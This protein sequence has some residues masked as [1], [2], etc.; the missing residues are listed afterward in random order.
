M[1]WM[2]IIVL[3]CLVGVVGDAGADDGFSSGCWSPEKSVQFWKEIDRRRRSSESVYKV[4]FCARGGSTVGHAFVAW[5][6]YDGKTRQCRIPVGYGFYPREGV[7][8]VSSVFG[9]VPGA[10]LDEAKNPNTRLLTHCLI[11]NVDEEVYKGSQRVIQKWK[12]RDYNL[13]RNNCISFLMD[14]GRAVGISVPGRSATDLPADYMIR[15]AQ[16]NR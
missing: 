15:L 10:I 12:T 9:Y 4:A 5:M 7:K 2:L 11:V 16:A 1:R 6:V 8:L 3:V 14:V 13:F